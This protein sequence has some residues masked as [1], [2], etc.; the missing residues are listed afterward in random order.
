VKSAPPRSCDV[1]AALVV[2]RIQAWRIRL[3][4]KA[5]LPSEIHDRA[6]LARLA[7]GVT[8]AELLEA[9][10]LRAAEIRRDPFSKSKGYFN[11]LSPFTGPG[12]NG[13]GGWAMSRG[14][15]DQNR[16]STGPKWDLDGFTPPGGVR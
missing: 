8:E 15:I 5:L 14:M 13:A 10:D 16:P 11:T 12:P 6:I 7:D 9:V 4:L 1:R 2:S 3:G